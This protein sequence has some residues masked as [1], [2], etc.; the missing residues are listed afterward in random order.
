MQAIKSVALRTQIGL[1][2]AC[3]YYIP[4]EGRQLRRAG[5]AVQA[6]RRLNC[7]WDNVPPGAV[8]SL[9]LG[10]TPACVS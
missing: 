1:M 8:D 9:T 10:E 3:R 7:N 6:T 2:Q 5:A 4:Q